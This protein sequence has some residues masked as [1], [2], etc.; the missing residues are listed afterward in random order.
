MK[1]INCTLTSFISII[2]LCICLLFIGC[3]SLGQTE[4]SLEE[5][6]EKLISSKDIQQARDMWLSRNISDYDMVVRF[7]PTGTHTPAS[8]VII[9][10]RNNETVSIEPVSEEDKRGLIIK[11]S[12]FET[13][14]KMFDKI[15]EELD[16]K[17]KV[18]GSFDS[19]IGYPK[20]INVFHTKTSEIYLLSIDKFDI[21]NKD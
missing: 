12:R 14:D 6:E 5:K 17:A 8:P 15:Q 16:N 13:V 18:R 10:V 21:I 11:Y 1:L 20:E 9:K 19:Q 3:Q 2:A 4:S 7:M